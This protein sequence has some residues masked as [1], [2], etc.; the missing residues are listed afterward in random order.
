MKTQ[1]F[2]KHFYDDAIYLSKENTKPIYV[3]LDHILCWEEERID[4]DTICSF[5]CTK[6]TIGCVCSPNH[7]SILVSETCEEINNIMQKEK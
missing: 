7:T 6:I 4:Y 1:I 2:N 3:P 5:T